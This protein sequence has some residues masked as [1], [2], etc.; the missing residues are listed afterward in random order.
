LSAPAVEE[1]AESSRR[2]AESLLHHQPGP[3]EAVLAADSIAAGFLGEPV[4]SGL[5]QRQR[6]R[7]RTVIRDHFVETLEP[8]RGVTGEVAWSA[9]RPE[10]DAVAVFLGLH[11]PAGTLKTRW[12]LVRAAGGWTVRDVFLT[13]PGISIAGEATRSIG[14]DAILRR[15]PV[16]SA[17]AAAFPRALGLA[18]IVVIVLAVGRRLSPNGRRILFLT[19]AAPAVLFLVDGGLAVRRALSESYS[20]PEVLPPA[21]WRAEERKALRAQREGR[22]DDAARAWKRAVAAGAPAAPADYQM[23]LA[24]AAAGRKEEAKAA[25]LRALTRSPAAPGASKELA[26][27]ALAQGNSAEARDRLESYLA[28]A[29]PDPDSLSALAVA[30]ANVGESERAVESV[31]QARVLMAD[32]WKGV[33]LQSQV[34]ARAGNAAKTV[35][36][37]RM[38]ESEGGLDRESLR[39][40]PAYLPIATDPAWVAFLSETPAAARTPTPPP[41]RTPVR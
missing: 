28:E 6:D 8:P 7:I 4:W 16:R 24:L 5:S 39:S 22:L 20:V 3:F 37:L 15:D 27:A 23:G 40:D 38:L 9:G 35:E 1:A 11:Y 29:G 19:A 12:S 13:D 30:Q 33:R 31:E 17:R 2:A 26:L 34:Y 18:A 36:T 14:R 21:P 32:R 41:A 25:F 10:G